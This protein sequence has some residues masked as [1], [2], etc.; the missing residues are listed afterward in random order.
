M[1]T[2]KLDKQRNCKEFE[3]GVEVKKTGKISY[4]LGIQMLNSVL[5]EIEIL[6]TSYSNPA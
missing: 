3:Q 4:D 5:I 6:V 2:N 1:K